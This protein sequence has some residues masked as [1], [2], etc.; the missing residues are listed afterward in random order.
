MEGWLAL[1][2]VVRYHQPPSRRFRGLD[3]RCSKDPAHEAEENVS[4]LRAVLPILTSPGAYQNICALCC[5]DSSTSNSVLALVEQSQLLQLFL[6]PV[7]GN[8][9]FVDTLIDLL[10]SGHLRS[11][12]VCDEY[13]DWSA[14]QHTRV[15]EAIS[16]APPDRSLTRLSIHVSRRAHAEALLPLVAHTATHT[17]HAV[18]IELP[19]GSLEERADAVVQ[20]L[21]LL[22]IPTL[23]IFSR[24]P[25]HAAFTF[26]HV[27]ALRFAVHARARIGAA[28]LRMLVIGEGPMHQEMR[29]VME[30]ESPSTSVVTSG[31]DAHGDMVRC[32]WVRF[33]RYT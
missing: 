26:A 23:R 27:D 16:M 1:A 11:L 6:M 13:A 32:E 9:S 15:M 22:T 7:Y 33:D 8:S 10:G 17:L 19:I 25:N 20:A 2:Q 3:L 12:C 21:Q 31:S 24:N 4:V 18:F 5:N 14:E 28:P 30:R 29:S